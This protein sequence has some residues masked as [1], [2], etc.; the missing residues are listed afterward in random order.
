MRKTGSKNS[1]SGW[2]RTADQGLMRKLVE[3]QPVAC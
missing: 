3:K 2:I 1:D